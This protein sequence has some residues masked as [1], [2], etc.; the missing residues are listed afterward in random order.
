M[1]FISLIFS[2]LI[3]L[4]VVS[5]AQEQQFAAIGDFKFKIADW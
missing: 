5:F 3:F 2:L 4:N 1:K